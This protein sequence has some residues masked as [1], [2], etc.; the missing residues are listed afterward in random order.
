MKTYTKL[1]E[2][3]CSKENLLKAYQKAKKGKSKKKGVI[4]F[5][6]NL[7]Y[8]INLL[9]KE[10]LEYKYKPQELRK[11]IVRDP[12]TR[13]IHASAFRDRVIHHAII[14]ILE[15]IYEKIFIYDSFAS[16]KNKGAHRAVKRFDYFK[17]RFLV[18]VNC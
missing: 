11:F 15:P 3:L 8:E 9:Q 12:K 5:S 7:D 1:Y 18:M 16:R 10:L 6:K 13:K 2:K 14:N 17:K 4:E